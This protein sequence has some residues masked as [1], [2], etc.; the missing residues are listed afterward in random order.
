LTDLSRRIVVDV[1]PDRQKSTLIAWLRRP[2]DGIDFSALAFAATDLWSHYRAAVHTVFPAVAVVADRF[3]VVQNL[4]AVIHT[5]RRDEQK[6]AAD[7]EQRAELKGLRYLLL[8]NEHNLTDSDQERLAQLAHAHPG[9]Y[10][11]WRLRQDL[12]DWYETD[13]TPDQAQL[14]LD[15]WMVNARQ[16]GLKYLDAFCNTLT[17]WRTEIVNFFHHRLTSGFVEGMNSKIRVLKRIAFG[18]PNFEHFRLR[19][20]AFCG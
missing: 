11:L 4:H 16:L 3:H 10:R 6:A 5:V 18:I 13:A 17:A 7:D 1:L 9:L 19:L 2:P 14:A 15:A 12:H 8:K 20:I